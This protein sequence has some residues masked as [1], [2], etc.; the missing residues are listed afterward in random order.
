MKIKVID[1]QY[2]SLTIFLQ[3]REGNFERRDK[4]VLLLHRDGETKRER[5][6]FRQQLNF[7]KVHRT[8]LVRVKQICSGFLST[9]KPHRTKKPYICIEY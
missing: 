8:I 5:V 4:I 9:D 2:P 7:S 6:R 1:I 3:E